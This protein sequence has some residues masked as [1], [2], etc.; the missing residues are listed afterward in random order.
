MTA[1]NGGGAA[2]PRLPGTGTGGGQTVQSA[3]ATF[4][5]TFPKDTGSAKTRRPKYIS[6]ATKSISLQVTDTKNHGNGTDIYANVPAALKAVQFVNFANLTG[7]PNIPGQCG[8]DPSNAGNFKCTALFLLPVGDDTITMKSWDAN[9]A[10]GN[11]LSENQTTVT[12][13]QGFGNSFAITLDANANVMTVGATS[14]FCAGSFTVSPG[15]TVPTV[16]TA[17]I[18]FSVSFTDLAGKTIVNPGEPTLKIGGSS[19][20]GTVIGTGGN[21]NFN[22]NQSTQTFTLSATTNNTSATIP[23]TA[24][25]PNA[26]DGLS[27]SKSLS[28]TY[29]SGPGLPASF[30]ADAQQIINGSGTVTGGV[31]DLWTVSLGASDTITPYS[32]AQL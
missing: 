21:V 4:T 9:G 30:L 24:V 29:Q 17:P 3:S 11:I 23:L 6:S 27:F 19:T 26:G 7:N 18:T 15:Q 16:G 13:V 8:S 32:T 22:I 20:S 5:F 31:V 10:T 28:F 12:T 2:A 25:P 1:C 14:G